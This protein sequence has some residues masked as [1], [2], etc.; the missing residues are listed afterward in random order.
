MLGIQHK[1][2]SSHQACLLIFLQSLDIEL[3]RLSRC[4]CVSSF[5][6]F[7]QLPF[8]WLY[9]FCVRFHHPATLCC[10]SFSY[11]VDL[12]I[13]WFQNDIITLRFQLN[14]TSAACAFNKHRL[15]RTVLANSYT[16]QHKQTQPNFRPYNP[17]KEAGLTASKRVMANQMN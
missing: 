17:K 5:S 15:K 4:V 3:A 1:K 12:C 14:I 7:K 13:R 6:S 11:Y 9:H 2:Q 10:C 16:H 8:S